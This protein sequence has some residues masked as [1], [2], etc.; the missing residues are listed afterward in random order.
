MAII[1]LD[2]DLE[3]VQSSYEAMPAGNYEARI[4]EA[5]LTNAKSSGAPMVKVVWEISDGEFAGR[6]V[7]DNVVLNVPWKV[8]QYAEVVGIESGSELDTDAFVGSEAIIELSV[9][10]YQGEPRNRIKKVVSV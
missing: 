1:N 4:A 5:E 6:K 7:F 2:F 9:E 3:D 10:E 8:K